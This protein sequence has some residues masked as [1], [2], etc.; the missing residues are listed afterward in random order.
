MALKFR[1]LSVP[2]AKQ[3]IRHRAINSTDPLAS[4]SSHEAASQPLTT[5]HM[6]LMVGIGGAIGTRLASILVASPV[7]KGAVRQTAFESGVDSSVACFARTRV[8]IPSSANPRA[9][10][11]DFASVA[12]SRNLNLRQT[13]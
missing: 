1:H 8:S 7:L 13:T 11:R 9:Q 6:S 4:Q 5:G 3:A 10:F 12:K 2:Q